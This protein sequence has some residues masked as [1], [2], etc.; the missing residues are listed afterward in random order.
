MEKGCRLIK[1]YYSCLLFL[2]KSRTQRQNNFNKKKLLLLLEQI[3]SL[4]EMS[5][6]NHLL[7]CVPTVA[8]SCKN[9]LLLLGDIFVRLETMIENRRISFNRI[10]FSCYWKPF[11]IFFFCQKK[12]FFRIVE[13]YFLMNASF[14]LLEKDFIFNG[15][16]LHYLRVLSYQ[17]K[18][19][20]I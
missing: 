1:S 16:C 3:F 20:L 13:A 11:Q 15:N 12:Q 6:R 2:S 8:A 7:L 19:S 4:V 18:S 5:F 9:K 10:I 14:Q 17:P